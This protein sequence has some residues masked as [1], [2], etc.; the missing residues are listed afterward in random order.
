MNKFMN[1]L[2]DAFTEVGPNFCMSLDDC[3][4][5]WKGTFPLAIY[6]CRYVDTAS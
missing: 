4:K 2:K 3:D 6:G 1:I 5:L